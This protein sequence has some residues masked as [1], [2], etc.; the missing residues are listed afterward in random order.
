MSRLFAAIYDPFMRRSERACLA[1]WRARLLFEVTGDVVEIGAGTGANLPVYPRAL[2][3]LALVEPDP[4]MRARLQARTHSDGPDVARVVAGDACSLPLP[5]GSADVVVSTLVLCSVPDVARALAEAKR[6]LR[7]GGRFVFLEHV[8][9]E[10][11]PDR[12]AWQRRIE[13]LWKRV[14][15]NCHVTRRTESAIVAAGFDVER[16]ER[17][18]MRRALPWI[19]PTIRGVAIRA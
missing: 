4:H 14:A 13:P 12:L 11:R 17:E 9:A 10:D 7:P 18:S 19:R 6:V 2:R 8:A 16:V 1:Q 15:G 3:S 5:D